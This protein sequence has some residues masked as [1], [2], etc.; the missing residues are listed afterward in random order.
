MACFDNFVHSPCLY[1]PAYYTCKAVF[2]GDT[3][4]AGLQD[5]RDTG[6]SPRIIPLVSILLVCV[7]MGI[8]KSMLG[9][10]ASSSIHQLL[11]HAAAV[12]YRLDRRGGVRLGGRPP[13]AIRVQGCTPGALHIS[14]VLRAPTWATAHHSLPEVI[15]SAIA[16]MVPD[17]AEKP[18]ESASPKLT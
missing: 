2:N 18:L 6:A 13:I 3:A 10:V 4:S 9:G 12:S 8:A 15:L 14:K 17:A 1:F 16:P 7:R 11:S 5:Y